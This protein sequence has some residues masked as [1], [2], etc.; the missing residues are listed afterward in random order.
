MKTN[1]LNKDAE[2]IVETVIEKAIYGGDGLG[3][4]EDGRAV[5]VPYVIPGER[6]R[7][8]L[9]EQKRGY[10]R[11]ELVKVLE[12]HEERIAPRCKHFGVCGGCHYQQL[13]YP[14]QLELKQGVV[15]DQLQR[16]GGMEEPS[17][18]PTFPAP[19]DWQYRNHVQF[20]LTPKG[21]MGYVDTQGTKITPI[22]ECFLMN[23]MLDELWRQLEIDAMTGLT[24]VS[25]R[26][27]NLGEVMLILESGDPQPIEFSTDSPI[28]VVYR[29]PGGEIVLAGEDYIEHEVLEKTFRV[30]ASAFFQVNIF[31][32]AM[33]VLNV[34]ENLSLSGEET[35]V[36]AYCGV[37]LFSAFLAERVKKVIG[38]ETSS[39]AC[40]DYEVNLSAFDN[41]SLYEAPVE[42]V[43]PSLDVKPD[44]ILLDPPRSGLDKKV[45]DAIIKMSPERLVY[46]SCDPATLARD[47]RRL[48]NGG[49]QMEQITPFDMFP[50]T[51]HIESI[52][53]WK[54]NA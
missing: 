19:F 8:R 27:S 34:L 11:G 39:A 33:M 46:V 31:V 17:V 24:K 32:A 9:T 13:P 7:I 40:A 35:L 21:K 26:C 22:D 47:A 44:V 53:Y 41:V 15:L 49:Y 20:H 25:M 38:I 3:R 37:G 42:N 43:L 54:L 52:S 23:P 18:M 14:M 1:G 16:I 10:A 28:S 50:Q 12:P 4:L 5:F 30:S 36:D 2:M 6:V 29:G 51:Y 45:I 48:V